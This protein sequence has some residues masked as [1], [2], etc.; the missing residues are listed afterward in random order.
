M[1][2]KLEEICAIITE[3]NNQFKDLDKTTFI[4]VCISEFLSL[5]ETER[6]IQELTTYHINT[7]NIVSFIKQAC[8]LKN[9]KAYIKA[10]MLGC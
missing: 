3:V 10:S 4:C 5:Y 7:H 9:L 1:F 2:G 6:M 8:F